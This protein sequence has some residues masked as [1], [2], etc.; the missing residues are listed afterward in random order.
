MQSLRIRFG[1]DHCIGSERRGPVQDFM[2]H[3]AESEPR[4]ADPKLGEL[5]MGPGGHPAQHGDLIG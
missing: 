2:L 5:A 1:E 4:I 3:G